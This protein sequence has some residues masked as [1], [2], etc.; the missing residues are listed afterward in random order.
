MG[1]PSWRPFRR[2]LAAIACDTTCTLYQLTLHHLGSP[3]LAYLTALLSL[4]PSNPATLYFVPYTEPFFTYLSYKGMLCCAQKRWMPAAL[5]FAL[6]GTF[7]SN[8][9]LLSGFILWGL[10][11]QQF[12]EHHKL[13]LRMLPY[14]T[15]LASIVLTPFVYHNYSGYILFCTNTQPSTSPPAWCHSFPPSIY[16]HAQSQYWNV[17]FLRYWTFA[18]V[19]NFIMAA[20]PLAALSL[21][22][23]YHLRYSIPLRL[24]S[25]SLR[26]PLTHSKP[27]ISSSIFFHPALTPHAIHALFLST[28]VLLASHVQIILRFAASMPFTYWAAV[29]LVTE[30]PK[31]GRWWLG[32]SLVWSSFSVVLWGVSLPPA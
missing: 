3:T 20:P 7:R 23:L 15:L 19:P 8:G 2:A 26:Y 13:S 4:M 31:L 14:P 29:W 22:S 18:Q 28:T 32:W 1:L 5:L 12:L 11:V 25:R 9:V 30:T 24:Q 27:I 6:A 21:F 17:G 10:L 16:T